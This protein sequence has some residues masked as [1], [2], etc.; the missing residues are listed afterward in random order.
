MPDSAIY[1]ALKRMGEE[2]MDEVIRHEG[3]LAV[4]V[5]SWAFKHDPSIAVIWIVIDSNL[6]VYKHGLRVAIENCGRGKYPA[7]QFIQR[8]EQESEALIR[9]WIEMKQRRARTE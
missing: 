8:G 7:G 6:N 3:W 1:I 4:R 5:E 2:V 9:E